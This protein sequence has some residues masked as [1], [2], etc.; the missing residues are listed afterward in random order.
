MA[1]VCQKEIMGKLKMSDLSFMLT[2][3]EFINSYKD[4][5]PS[6]GPLGYF[7][8]KRTYAR[9]IESGG[10]EEFWQTCLR[11]VNGVF[12]I[13]KDHCKSLALPW[14]DARAEKSAKEMF[15]RMWD[16]KFLPPGRGLW[17]M[18]TDIVAKKGGAALNNCAFISTKDLSRDFAAPF[19]F[20]MD[21]SMLGVGVGADVDGAEVFNNKDGKYL[22]DVMIVSPK[23]NED[24]VFTVED[25]REGWVNLLRHV[26]NSY[27]GINELAVEIDYSKIRAKG[28]P[29]KTFGGISSGPAP[30]M[31]LIDDV[32]R[33]LQLAPGET[34]SLITPSQIADLFN[35]IG[36][37]VVSGGVRRSAEILFGSPENSEFLE[38]KQ[39]KDALWDRRWVS[40]NSIKGKLG[41]DYSKV[42]E[43]IAINGEPGII[44]LENMQAYSRLLNEPDFKD[45]KV[46]GTNPCA[47]QS[48]EPFELCCLVETFPARHET[49]E[50]FFETLKYAYMYAKTVTLVPTH[51]SRT[52]SVTMRNR[53]IGCSQSGIVQAIEKFGRDKFFVY[54][55]NYGYDVIRR[56]DK[57]Y[58]DWLCVPQSI[59]VTSVKPSGTV[60]LLPGSTPGIHY[61][62]SEYYIRRIR[63]EDTSPLLQEAI[64][65]G[66]EVEVDTYA[67]NTYCVLFPVKEPYFT[68]GKTEVT[69]WEQFNNAV[70]MQCYWADNQVSV[71]VTF[72]P[73][74]AKYIK[75]C[76]ETFQRR[77]KSVSF[78]PNQDHG[79]VQPP[80][81]TVGED[82][83]LELKNKIKWEIGSRAIHDIDDKFCD[84]DK[85]KI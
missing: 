71:T 17:V 60:S 79:Y 58:S 81:E 8:Y 66:Y 51:N 22:G 75:P 46:L 83:F 52:N 70:D 37:C 68:K 50:D 38:L 3:A 2:D 65:A 39:D 54:M 80:Y 18:G 45:E 31:Q 76:L 63:V 40:N 23:V 41:Q 44:W 43:S 36:K 42:A 77:L 53:R 73:D 4:K 55:C 61:A 5:Q 59:K 21:M 82:R 30:L 14:D 67:P 6:W 56:W 84:G 26:L 32:K 11:V 19:C 25:T 29:L 34:S 72:N 27:V 85:C 16:F 47:E 24:L 69:I 10:T 35:Y 7:T 13:Q 15:Q 74:E 62:H 78:L 48:L 9:P 33:T 57:I 64:L 1:I 20:L 49:P 28:E 12:S